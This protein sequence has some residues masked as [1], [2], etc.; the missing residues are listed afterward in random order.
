MSY[1][2][3][4]NILVQGAVGDILR[5]ELGWDIVFAYNKEKL[6]TNGT[7][8]RTSY[9]EILLVWYFHNALK[10][11]KPWITDTQITEFENEHMSTASLTQINE[12]KYG[13]IRDGMPVTM[14]C[15]DGKTETKK[16]KVINFNEPERA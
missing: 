13:Y 3:F 2:Y 4:E 9:K 6:G 15:P 14:K 5:D 12:E 16:S 8:D 11:L 7:L 10:N 1:D